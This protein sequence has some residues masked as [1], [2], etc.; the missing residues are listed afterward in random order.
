MR[1]VVF[2]N[3]SDA[4]TYRGTGRL[5]LAVKCAHGEE[6]KGRKRRRLRVSFGMGVHR[7]QPSAGEERY[8]KE[9]A[10]CKGRR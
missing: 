10:S 7:E 1:R 2:E 9:C 4:M 8:R 5:A 3:D 6:S